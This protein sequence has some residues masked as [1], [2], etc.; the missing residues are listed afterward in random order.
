MDSPQVVT[1]GS[2]QLT[3]KRTAMM[4]LFAQKSLCVFLIISLDPLIKDVLLD[5][6]LWNIL[7]FPN[8]FI[9]I[10]FQFTFLPEM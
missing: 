4:S 3:T 7:H 1:L 8:C 6:Q 5:G 2:F 10:L 9:R